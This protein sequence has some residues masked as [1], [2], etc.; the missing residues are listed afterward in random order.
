M[1]TLLA[2]GNGESLAGIKQDRVRPL[3]KDE[4]RKEYRRGESERAENSRSLALTYPELRS[5]RV[6]LVYFEGE[7]VS[8]GQGVKYRAN[9]NSARSVLRFSCPSSVC[10]GGDF[11]LSNELRV[12]VA[13][14]RTAANGELRCQGSRDQESGDTIRCA[15]ILHYKMSLAFKKPS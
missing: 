12:A 1:K 5:L 7:V 15:S 13:E 6:D 10:K 11:D 9:L 14:R 2:E 8:W 3:R 4:L